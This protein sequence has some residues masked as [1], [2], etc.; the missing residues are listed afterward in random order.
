M[1]NV[2]LMMTFT[3]YATYNI[4]THIRSLGEVNVLN[5]CHRILSK[6]VF[7][8]SILCSCNKLSWCLQYVVFLDLIYCY[9]EE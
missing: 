9:K 4:N 2:L 3:F 6:L 8:Y 5:Y 1:M 7:F